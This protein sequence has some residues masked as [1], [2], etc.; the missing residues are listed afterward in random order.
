LGQLPPNATTTRKESKLAPAVAHNDV[1]Q[2]PN[3]SDSPAEP[4]GEFA[5]GA[6]LAF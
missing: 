3:D 4:D 2:H 6:T 5:L 1:G